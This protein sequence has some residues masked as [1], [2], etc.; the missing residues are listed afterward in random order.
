MYY[1]ILFAILLLFLILFL[2]KT[3]LI[4]GIENQ[5]EEKYEPY[6]QNNPMILAEKN[7]A[8]L[9]YLKSRLDRWAIQKSKF[10]IYKTS[11]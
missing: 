4:E 11:N 8:N 1:V 6:S 3:S 10:T 7:A 5:D 2:H 9:E